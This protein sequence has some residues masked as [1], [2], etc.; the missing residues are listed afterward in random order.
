MTW[1]DQRQPASFKGVTF[2]VTTDSQPAGPRTQVHEYPQ[3]DKPFVEALGLKT[4]EIKISGFVAGEDC[5]AKRDALLKV[6]DEGGAGELIHPW[7]GSLTVVCTDCSYSHDRAAMG[8]VRF[9]L[10]F[11][12]G[13]SDPSY[14]VASES[15]ASVLNAA[16]DGVQASAVDRFVAML[17]SIDLTQV[18]P[19]AVLGAIGQVTS[20]LQSVYDTASDV[21]RSASG[22]IDRV[23][24]GPLEFATSLFNE[25]QG[26]ATGFSGFY[27][28]LSGMTSLFGLGSKLDALGRL[29]SFGSPGGQAN[30]TFVRAVQD[31]GR[32][33]VV[34]DVLRSV[35]L[36]PSKTSGA[37]VSGAVGVDGMTPRSVSVGATDTDAAVSGSLVVARVTPPVTDDVLAL[38]DS[39]SDAF[40]SVAE[41]SPATHYERVAAGRI[42][43]TRQ[44]TVVARLGVKL[45]R[46]ENPAPVPALVLAY[47]RY[48]D[49][50][51]T[52]DIVA[53]NSVQHPGFVPAGDLLVPK[54]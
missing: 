46:V 31:L 4:R 45:A 44:L 36:L 7:L 39:L 33:V 49:V 26:A 5:L 23:L 38:R 6:I 17:D 30:G 12:E 43:A 1:R 52:A 18:R 28:R 19:D 22:V 20:T 47:R 34:A 54:T 53:R 16:A 25:V 8:V 35:A 13:E 32:D 41:S 37:A 3:R 10:T 50:A 51:K 42:A 40:W 15:A 11:V 27:S 29:G 24:G 14:P 2:E 21:V 9:D 48:G